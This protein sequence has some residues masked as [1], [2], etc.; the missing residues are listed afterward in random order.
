[1]AGLI[2][3]HMLRRHQ[4]TILEASSALPHNH[5]ALLRFRSDAVAKATSIPFKKV[6]VR[7]GCLSKKGEVMEW[8]QIAD[9]N[10]YSE[11]VSGLVTLRSISE[12]SACDRWAAPE[13]FSHKL[14]APLDKLHF[15]CP[16]TPLNIGSKPDEPWVSTIPMPMMMELVGWDSV[17]G[18]TFQHKPIYVINATIDWPL[19][20][21]YQTI[22]IPHDNQYPG[23]Y[24]V[25]IHNNQLI[26]E[27]IGEIPLNELRME[28]DGQLCLHILRELFGFT[29]PV[30]KKTERR[31]QKY[32]KMVAIDEF[33]RKRFIL[34]LTENHNI[35]SLGRF[36]TWR[37]LL[38]DDV[39]RD[40][41]VIDG[42]LEKSP[43]DRAK[44]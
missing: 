38:L 43:Y 39:V 33:E 5:S 34:W 29:N 28:T 15:N 12:L 16:V 21:V 40:V 7:K 36:A 9:I 24:R 20:S 26:I 8:P 22:Y 30:V 2:A 35:Y 14:A 23:I 1:M 44:H 19:T 4:P 18:T 32:G 41:E 17:I 25:S 42:L 27:S 13:D 3:G 37:P 31:I 11:K 10:A 6:R